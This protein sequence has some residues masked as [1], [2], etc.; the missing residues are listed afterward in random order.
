[1]WL[2]QSEA[3]IE[4]VDMLPLHAVAAAALL[5]EAWLESIIGLG[6]EKRGCE[7]KDEES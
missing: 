1:M 6:I 2:D 4:T 7:K 3:R 5:D